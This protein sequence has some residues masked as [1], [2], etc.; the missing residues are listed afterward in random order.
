MSY[1]SPPPAKGVNEFPDYDEPHEEFM[2]IY[3]RSLPETTGGATRR[4]R[5]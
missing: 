5:R 4:W 3:A 1:S 2:R